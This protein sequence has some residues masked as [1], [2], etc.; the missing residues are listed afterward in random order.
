MFFVVAAILTIIL[1][2]FIFHML[3]LRWLIKNNKDFKP[4]GKIKV[5]YLVIFGTLGYP[6][7]NGI[8]MKS[9][10]EYIKKEASP[11]VKK[12]F[13]YTSKDLDPVY[14]KDIGCGK[15]PDQ[16]IKV[17]C[18]GSKHSYWRWKS[19]VIWEALSQ[20][21]DG[22]ILLYMDCNVQKYPHLKMHLDKI[23]ETCQKIL[24]I[25]KSDIG[26][27]TTFVGIRNW[28]F[29][30]NGN[31][32]HHVTADKIVFRKSKLSLD[33]VSTWH[34]LCMTGL[35]LPPIKQDIWM[36]SHL[37]DQAVFNILIGV[38]KNLKVIPIDWPNLTIYPHGIFGP[39][40]IIKGRCSPF[41]GFYLFIYAAWSNIM[42]DYLPCFL[43]ERYTRCEHY[44][45]IR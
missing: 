38:M 42:R 43:E 19:R 16:M 26:A 5:P 31:W 21:N 8:D 45:C 1:T 12:V 30:K 39:D 32:D 6:Y 17:H 11:Y 34:R 40:N 22:E 24:S 27:T 25:S 29:V 44:M 36:I 10:L 23:P 4:R 2:P 41:F 14:T 35:I 13:V 33:F 9:N 37:H 20:I 15:Y 28:S 3:H 7:D 18:N